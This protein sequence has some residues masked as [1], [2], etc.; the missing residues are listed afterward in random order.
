MN[1]GDELAIR[2]ANN[3]A[4][5]KGVN[6]ELSHIPGEA[7]EIIHGEAESWREAMKDCEPG[8][9]EPWPGWIGLLDDGDHYDADGSTD[10]YRIASLWTRRKEIGN[11]LGK[12][13][14]AI[15]AH[16]RKLIRMGGES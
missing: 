13:R 11:D 9:C 16:G 3:R 2:Y 15:A 1:R 12:I 6:Q 7:F 14:R 8:C 10:A 4:E 5:L